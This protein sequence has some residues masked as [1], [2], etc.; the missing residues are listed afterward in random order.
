MRRASSADLEMTRSS[1]TRAVMS[2]TIAVEKLPLI[3]ERDEVTMFRRFGS[4]HTSDSSQPNCF[5][6]RATGAGERV[7][8]DRRQYGFRPPSGGRY[9]SPPA[10]NPL[11]YDTL[12]GFSG[13]SGWARRSTRPR[14]W[15]QIR[16]TRRRQPVWLCHPTRRAMSGQPLRPGPVR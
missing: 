5:T 4:S 7:L 8:V 6:F 13:K 10:G 11:T 15:L 12:T 2:R 16:K 3:F 14:A 9:R 1:S